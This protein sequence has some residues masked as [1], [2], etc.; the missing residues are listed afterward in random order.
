MNQKA[1]KEK[2]LISTVFNTISYH[3]KYNSKSKCIRQLFNIPKEEKYVTDIEVPRGIVYDEQFE[4]Q[5][6]RSVLQPAPGAP[7]QSLTSF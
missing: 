4:F 3:I 1:S 5:M 6:Q 7:L 2:R